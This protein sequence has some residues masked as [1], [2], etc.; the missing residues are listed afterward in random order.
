MKE[1]PQIL[2]YNNIGI[3][4]LKCAQSDLQSPLQAAA[5]FYEPAKNDLVRMNGLS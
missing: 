4:M 2:V 1:S 3:P 5:Y